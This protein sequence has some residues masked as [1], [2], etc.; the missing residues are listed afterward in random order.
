MLGK[1]TIAW[2]FNKQTLTRGEFLDLDPNR[3]IVET[4]LQNFD[5]AYTDITRLLDLMWNGPKKDSWPNFGAA[6]GKMMELRVKA[7][8]SLNLNEVPTTQLVGLFA[9]SSAANVCERSGVRVSVVVN[10]P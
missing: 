5:S 10:G 7:C 8:F 6:V 1:I 3:K 4:D 9:K 2:G